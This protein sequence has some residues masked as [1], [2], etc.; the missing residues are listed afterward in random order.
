MGLGLPII[1][2]NAGGIKDILGPKNSLVIC[3]DITDRDKFKE[4]LNNLLYDNESCNNLVQENLEYVK[5][6]ST[7]NV[8]NM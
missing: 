2:T 1:T 7:S 5:K 6:F 4:S 8:A 3:R